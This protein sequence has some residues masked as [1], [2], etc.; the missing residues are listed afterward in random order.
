MVVQGRLDVA[1]TMA[2]TAA[3]HQQMA[4]AEPEVHIPTLNKDAPVRVVAGQGQ[5]KEQVQGK[6]HG[7]KDNQGLVR[8]TQTGG[9]KYTT[10]VRLF[11]SAFFIYEAGNSVNNG[12]QFSRSGVQ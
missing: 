3:D 11:E 5:L 4:V 9:L 8:T 12:S 7:L 6:K 2:T 1:K 10:P